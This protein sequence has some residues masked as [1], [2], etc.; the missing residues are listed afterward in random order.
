MVKKWIKLGFITILTF[1]V[2]TACKIQTVDEYQ[3][4][5]KAAQTST[6]ET[7]QQ[8]KQKEIT[9]SKEE[10]NTE[11]NNAEDKTKTQDK[12]KQ[13]PVK[14]ENTKKEQTNPNKSKKVASSN[15][16]DK[17][18]TK[19]QDTSK[20]QKENTT[21]PVNKGNDLSPSKK[22]DQA[23]TKPTN[24]EKPANENKP[25]KKYV[26]ISIRVDTILDNYDK[27]DKSLRSEQFVP[28]NGIILDTT[29][30]E[31]RDNENVFD[32]LVRATRDHRIHMEYQ[33]ANENKY[34]SVY[35]EGINHVYEFS[36]GELSGWMYSVNGWYPNYGAS[37]YYLKDG[38]KIEWNYTCDLGRDLGVTW[39]E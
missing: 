34:G 32:I 22:G 35:I 12:K 15:N 13:D 27:L 23:A 3:N 33:G 2:L 1:M 24:N 6:T 20:K 37:K 31:L 36:V 25:K 19:K 9:A 18:E 4:E 30:Y 7:N 38:D 29:K 16:K 5:E 8:D 11:K 10:K 26:T 21:T 28:K 39:D 14:K 17:K